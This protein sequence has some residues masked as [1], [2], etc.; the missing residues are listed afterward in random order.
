[1]F[2]PKLSFR[3]VAPEMFLSG[4][5]HESLFFKGEADG[6]ADRPSDLAIQLLTHISETQKTSKH[7]D[8][9][10]DK[11]HDSRLFNL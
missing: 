10:F 3:Y 11:A 2:S 6:R 1:V 4:L 8:E 7:F 5:C 9:N